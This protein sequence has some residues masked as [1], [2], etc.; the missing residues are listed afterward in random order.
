MRR[1]NLWSANLF[2]WFHSNISVNKWVYIFFFQFSY[3]LSQFSVLSI[4]LVSKRLYM[5]I[6]M[7]F[8]SVFTKTIA[9]FIS[10]CINRCFVNKALRKT[11]TIHRTV[12]FLTAVANFN[13]R[14]CWIFYNFRIMFSG[15]II[16]GRHITNLILCFYRI[17]YD[18]YG[19]G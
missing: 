7:L 17:A 12:C 4:R 14:W 8:E 2:P 11:V 15:D 3:I 6:I 10:S 18:I 1:S 13:G 16:H 5:V 9:I 19:D